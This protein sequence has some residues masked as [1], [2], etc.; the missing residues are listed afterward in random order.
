MKKHLCCLFTFLSVSCFASATIDSELYLA[1]KVVVHPE[2]GYYVLSDGSMWKVFA[3]HPRWRTLSEWWN[4]V[5]IVPEE[6]DC[7]PDD[8][9]LGVPIK[10]IQRHGF[11]KFDET[12]ASNAATLNSCGHIIV[13]LVS[14][15]G[16]FAY[17]L[18]PENA[19][20]DVYHEGYRTGHAKGYFEGEVDGSKRTKKYYEQSLQE[21]NRNNSR[22]QQ[23]N[24]D[25]SE[26]PQ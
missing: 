24:Y 22:N 7:K 16:L 17:A 19:L 4:S 3:L 18:K 23:V 13:N 14:N 21:M 2:C 12:V 11:V 6:L 25:D 20:F 9:Y 1:S 26:D 10:V 8:F 15:K 5:K